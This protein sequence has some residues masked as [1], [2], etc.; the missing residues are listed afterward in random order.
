MAD[1]RE[2]LNDVPLDVKLFI[3]R[4]VMQF[5]RQYVEDT[6]TPIDDFAFSIFRRIVADILDIDPDDP[7]NE[8][9]PADQHDGAS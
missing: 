5:G 8:R 9:G 6:S 3:F 1:I 2:F 4:R 7:K